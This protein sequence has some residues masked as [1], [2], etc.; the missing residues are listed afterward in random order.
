MVAL[1]PPGELAVEILVDHQGGDHL[2]VVDRRLERGPGVASR[3]I[4]A[5]I[6]A[7]RRDALDQLDRMRAPELRSRMPISTFFTS[8]VVA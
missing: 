3:S 5:E 2:L 8:S 4:R 7:C 6:G 1:S